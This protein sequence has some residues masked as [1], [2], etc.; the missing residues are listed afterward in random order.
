MV[1]VTINHNRWHDTVYHGRRY[2]GHHA[3]RYT[4]D[5]TV[6]VTEDVTLP[7]SLCSELHFLDHPSI[8]ILQSHNRYI[9]AKVCN[10]QSI[11]IYD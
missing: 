9:K 7:P 11:S 2:G 10:E 8:R 3:R 4:E 1:G 6:D 5:I